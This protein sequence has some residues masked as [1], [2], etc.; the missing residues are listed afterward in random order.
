MQ[1]LGGRDSADTDDGFD[2]APARRPAAPRPAQQA[3]PAAP[4]AAAD[5]SDMDDDIPF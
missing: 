5:L 3:R 4:A 2:Q 1:M